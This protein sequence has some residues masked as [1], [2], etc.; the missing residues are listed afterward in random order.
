[1]AHT[2]AT[3]DQST[4]NE[5]TQA[6]GDFGANEWVVED[7]Y[8]RYQADP[9]SVDAAWHDFFADY[10]PGFDARPGAQDRSDVDADAPSEPIAQ[11]A[12]SAPASSP[13]ASAAAAPAPSSAA[14]SA[15]SSAPTG[16]APPQPDN[17][18]PPAAPGTQLPKNDA[19]PAKA[20][21]PAPKQTVPAARVAEGDTSIQLRGAA[22]RV[23]VNMEASLTV[24]TA[25]SVRAVPAKLIAD[26]RVVIN[27]H[28]RRSRGGKIS[29]TH[30]IGFAVVRALLDFPEMNNHFAEV[31][32]KPAVAPRHLGAG[33]MFDWFPNELFQ[34]IF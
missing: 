23:V 20:D 31:D 12:T 21:V 22:S 1:M 18:R 10:R 30:I 14:A 16:L 17:G 9:S 3:T 32:G 27:N 8:E 2:V 19:A 13:G 34:L 11:S 26:N 6:I 28:L 5:P 33:K 24:P 4:S 7:M 29:F 25:T 15:S